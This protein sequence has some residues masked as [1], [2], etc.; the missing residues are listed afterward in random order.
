MPGNPSDSLIHALDETVRSAD[1]SNDG[2]PSLLQCFVEKLKQ[3][4]G[5]RIVGQAEVRVDLVVG[6]LSGTE[7]LD[8]NAR[9]FQHVPQT[10]RL[11]TRIRMLGNMQDQEWRN[12]FL[13]GHV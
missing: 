7:D 5:G 1:P 12:T 2:E 8:G 13:P 6:G 4:L 3:R 9:A 10:L 11:R